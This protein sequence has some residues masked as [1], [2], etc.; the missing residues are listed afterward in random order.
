MGSILTQTGGPSAAGDLTFAIGNDRLAILCAEAT[1]GVVS[2]SVVSW[3]IENAEAETYSILGPGFTVPFPSTSATAR[4]IKRHATSI[5]VQLAYERKPEFRLQDGKTPVEKQYEA[6]VKALKEIRD[7]ERALDNGQ[8][9]KLSGG[10]VYSGS[11]SFIV[12]PNEGSQAPS[13]GF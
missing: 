1:A 13:G 7:G 5:A 6:A 11:T 8:E 9:S 3:I 10:T 2:T 12:D 4:V